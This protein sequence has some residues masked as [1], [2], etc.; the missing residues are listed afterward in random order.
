[1]SANLSEMVRR[2]YPEKEAELAALRDCQMAGVQAGA[3]AFV[4]VGGG[5]FAAMRLYARTVSPLSINSAVGVSVGA[6]RSVEGGGGLG[7]LLVVSG[8]VDLLRLCLSCLRG[9][10]G[11]GWV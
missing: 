3:L 5:L 11:G 8:V 9:R 7:L 10:G 1:M 4:A 6:S 2:R